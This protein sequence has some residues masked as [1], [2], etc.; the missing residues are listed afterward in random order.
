MAGEKQSSIFELLQSKSAIGVLAICASLVS[1]LLPHPAPFVDERPAVTT[2][3]NSTFNDISGGVRSRKMEAR[4]WQDPFELQPAKASSLT[5]YE[6]IEMGGS[7]KASM[8]ARLIAKPDERKSEPKLVDAWDLVERSFNQSANA[9]AQFIIAPLNEGSSPEYA[10][11]RRRSRYAMISALAAKRYYPFNPEQISWFRFSGK[12]SA[13]EAEAKKCKDSDGRSPDEEPCQKVSRDESYVVHW[14][15]FVSLENRSATCLVSQA[16]DCNKIY[17]L[18]IPSANFT[19][20][21]EIISS[22]VSPNSEPLAKFQK[23]GISKN[24]PQEKKLTSPVFVLGPNES[25]TLHETTGPMRMVKLSS[26]L[27]FFSS[28][29]SIDACYLQYNLNKAELDDCIAPKFGESNSVIKVLPSNVIRTS[30]PD[31]LVVDQLIKELA[32]RGVS[33][34]GGQHVALI[35]DLDTEYARALTHTFA[36]KYERGRDKGGDKLHHHYNYIRGVDGRTAK[37]T[38]GND[39]VQADSVKQQELVKQKDSALGSGGGVD[40]PEGNSQKDYIRRLADQ[41][42]AKDEQLRL[43]EGAPFSTKRTGIAAIGVLG[44]D[45]YDKLMIL[46]ALRPIFP[47]KIFFTTDMDAAY[48]LPSELKHTRNLIVGS[49][50][51]L[52]LSEAVQGHVAPFR[53]SWQTAYYFSAL[54]AIGYAEGFNQMALDGAQY[55]ARQVS[56]APE[57][58]L[59]LLPRVY[60]IGTR[61]SVDLGSPFVNL[62]VQGGCPEGESLIFT[63]NKGIWGGVLPPVSDGRSNQSWLVFGAILLLLLA[64]VMVLEHR[65]LEVVYSAY[66]SIGR[67]AEV[68]VVLLFVVLGVS[69]FCLYIKESSYEE[70]FFWNNGI[71]IWPSEILRGLAILLTAVLFFVAKQKMDRVAL[72]IAPNFGLPVNDLSNKLARRSLS[73]SAK[74][75]WKIFRGRLQRQ[76]RASQLRRGSPPSKVERQYVS[77]TRIWRSYQRQSMSSRII[78][79]ETAVVVGLLLLNIFIFVDCVGE[80]HAPVRGEWSTYGNLIISTWAFLVVLGFTAYIGDTLRQFYHFSR[81]LDRQE[82]VWPI[83]LEN[84]YIGLASKW[85]LPKDYTVYWLD[86]EFIARQTEV[87]GALVWYPV[88][89]WVLLLT[90]RNRMFDDWGYPVGL[91]IGFAMIFI[92]LLHTAFYLQRSANTIREKAI[93]ELTRKLNELRGASGMAGGGDAK[94]E[95]KIQQAEAMIAEIRDLKRGAFLPLYQQPWVEALLALAGS[96]AL[97]S[98]WSGSIS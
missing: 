14:E 49:S 44:N 48:S 75:A 70:P 57:C 21:L 4:L 46:Q 8:R 68:A 77:V 22:E 69:A 53:N 66:Q 19:K 6:L 37:S 80:I 51:G 27:T 18:W 9:H 29:A 60:E 78:T 65:I 81:E 63:S 3:F 23:K 67:K 71:S 98:A 55:E 74:I 26:Y 45:V 41:I 10:E 35:S 85:K 54:L 33:A 62:S 24:P 42:R 43:E 31:N 97:L 76:V 90:A 52:N 86:V 83:G 12:T 39:G 59:T 56:L 2:S 38:G 28:G 1:G 89:G 92:W 30:S 87:I 50:F 11:N 13:E 88:V 91:L 25:D 72:E 79:R 73:R 58:R 82:S 7:T 61:Q 47:G 36:V 32:L 16:E 84:K 5:S 40:R 93:K 34:A 20:L 64:W 96:Q 15:K 95:I 94:R 17:V